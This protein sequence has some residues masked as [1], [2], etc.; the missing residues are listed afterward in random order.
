MVSMC[1]AL[2]QIKEDPF[3]A[4]QPGV[5]ETVCDELDYTWRSGPLDPAHTVALFVQQIAEG[6]IPCTE[7]RHLSDRQ[8]TDSAYCQARQRLPLAVVQA[9]SRRVAQAVARGT[10][11][12]ESSQWHGHAVWVVDG[13]TFSMPDTPELR[14]YFGQPTGQVPGCGFPVGHL[15]ALFQRD[16][17]LLQEPVISPL[18]TSD[19]RHTPLMHAQM[20]RGDA[21]LGDDSFSS[22]G[23]FALILRGGLHLLTPSHHKRIVSFRPHRPHTQEGKNAVAGRPRSR[24]IQSLGPRDQ[25]VEW[26]KPR[27]CPKWMTPED[28]AALPESIIVREI[29]RTVHRKGFRSITLTVVTTLLDAE[30]YPAD[31]LVALRMQRW[32]VET[33]LRH[34]KTTMKM[35][36]LH[37]K[38]VDGVKKEVAVFGLVYNLV[39]ALMFEAAD[40]QQVP[41]SRI[42]FADALHWLKHAGP[43]DE[44]PDLVVNPYR[45]DRVEPRV[46]K[47]RPKPYDLMTRPRDE[48]RKALRRRKKAS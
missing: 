12:A 26:F 22:W 8:F 14:A 36:T 30:L 37:C 45:P 27:Q 1:S 16:T 11:G 2:A 48:L 32:Q 20:G 42:S 38:S 19:L 5:I 28:Y 10:A 4:L 31:E 34:L 47:R 7:V 24:W 23:H 25:L 17:G 41:V 21:L 43:G 6:N 18:Y 46:I 15:L 3:Q 13:S 35:E 39:R 33:N 29:R 40:R 9:L 44:L